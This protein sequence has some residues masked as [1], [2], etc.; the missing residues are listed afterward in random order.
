[1][2]LTTLTKTE[3]RWRRRAVEAMERDEEW[4]KCGQCARFHPKDY[5]GE[6]GDT[7]YRLPRPPKELVEQQSDE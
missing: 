1:M 7:D 5:E 4:E 3:E 6:C 2:A